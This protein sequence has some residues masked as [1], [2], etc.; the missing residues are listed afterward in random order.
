MG[1][2]SAE[3]GV[4]R[5]AAIVSPDRD[6]SED[7]ARE[8]R[9]VLE[10]GSQGALAGWGRKRE[11]G[12]ARSHLEE[13][14]SLAEQLAERL[15]DADEASNQ[16]LAE[17]LQ[18]LG[19]DAGFQNHKGSDLLFF[20]EPDTLAKL[21]SGFVVRPLRRELA[22]ADELDQIAADRQHGRGGRRMALVPAA[23][24]D[25]LA[26]IWAA[27]SGQRFNHGPSGGWRKFVE[28]GF[29]IVG[30]DAS[31]EHYARQAAKGRSK[32]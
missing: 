30:I 11:R 17:A 29:E 21:I 26:G 19:D 12:D 10:M 20:A 14:A 31:A 6:S 15:L 27:H 25:S 18:S 28:T 13:T 3:D 4:R 32:D 7:L 8:L 23:V 9:R 1:A 2:T 22:L 16:A 5:L 24:A